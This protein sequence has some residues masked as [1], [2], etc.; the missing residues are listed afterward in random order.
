[1]NANIPDSPLRGILLANLAV[2]IF[3]LMDG[4]VKI[5]AEKYPIGQ[6]V[7]F[8]NL[9][10]FLPV[11]WFISRSGGMSLLRTRRPWAHIIR[12][13]VGVS[14]MASF[15]LSYKL[16]PLSEAIA[17]GLSAPIFITLL[18]VPFLGEKVGMRRAIAIA[19]GFIGVLFMT[20]PDI[21]GFGW[22]AWVAIFSAILY[23][24]AMI[25]IRKLGKSESSLTIVFYFTLFAMF[26]S[27][28]SLPW[29]WNNPDTKG[30]IL[31][32]V[33]GMMGGFGQIAI[34][35]AIKSAPVSIIAPFDYMALVYGMIIGNIFWDE[36]PSFHL[37]LGAALVIGSGLYILWRETRL[38]RSRSPISPIIDPA[39]TSDKG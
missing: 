16:L 29:Q 31:L 38:K 25:A 35:T 32:I 36:Q 33:I 6:I 18:S 13:I 2:I 24:F 30:L 12:G 4:L 1:M 37:L 5:V 26:T 22:G 11:L 9:C 15:F 28:L 8:R 7:F 17:I 21:N 3:T 39:M 27:G 14:A 19:I 23:A 34:T 10:A 20:R